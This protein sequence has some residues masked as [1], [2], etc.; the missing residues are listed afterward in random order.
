M[1]EQLQAFIDETS[2]WPQ[3]EIW[4]LNTFAIQFRTILS[5]QVKKMKGF[6]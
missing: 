3:H 1:A 2:V 6:F 4:E 5:A